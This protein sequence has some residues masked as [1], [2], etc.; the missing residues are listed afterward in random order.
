MTGRTSSLSLRPG[1]S[2]YAPFY[3][4]YVARVPHA[5]VLDLLREQRAELSRLPAMVPPDREGFAYAVGKWT[6]AEVV[7]HLG[8]A[9]RVFGYRVLRFSVADP[10]PLASFEE[11]SY[12]AES[13]PRSLADVTEELVALRSANL[14]LFAGLSEKQWRRTGTA[15]SALVSVRA[16]AFIIYGHAA[17]HLDVLRERYGLGEI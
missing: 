17:H 2:E 6:V 7:A 15:S 16:L 3:E 13:N 1:S 14:S 9:E 8:H 4:K 12:V 11:N 10:E 5:D